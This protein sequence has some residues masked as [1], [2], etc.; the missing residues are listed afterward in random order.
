[1][2]F[3]D[4]KLTQTD[5][6]NFFSY[7]KNNVFQELKN[8]VLIKQ[9]DESWTIE[10]LD[11]IYEEY[12]DMGMPAMRSVTYPEEYSSVEYYGYADDRSVLAHLEHIYAKKE[13]S[14]LTT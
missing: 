7:L 2:E 6:E 5:K 4:I 1:M 10:E 13:I 11:K 9:I 8:K 3:T 12:T 14:M